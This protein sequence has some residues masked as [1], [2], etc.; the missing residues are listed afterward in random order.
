MNGYYI[1]QQETS[2]T[3]RAFAFRNAAAAQHFIAAHRLRG[4][5]KGYAGRG[6]RLGPVEDLKDYDPEI[7]ELGKEA[8]TMTTT[9]QPATQTPAA[10]RPPAPASSPALAKVEE[11]QGEVAYLRDLVMRQHAE[12]KETLTRLAEGRAFD[13]IHADELRHSVD[14]II[15]LLEAKPAQAAPIAQPTAQQPTATTADASG[16]IEVLQGLVIKKG[17]NEKNGQTTI[18]ITTTDPRF[19]QYGVTVWPEALPALGIDPAALAFG[20]TPF[21]KKIKV[22]V[23]NGK[24][25]AIGL[26]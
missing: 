21:E 24:S 13:N 3:Y 26:A 12:L 11:L 5:R 19:S 8:L 15:G 16:T 7:E 1:A 23:N 18:K 22:A 17:V 9:P 2:N 6:R 14:R 10:V 20:A 4:V 25:K